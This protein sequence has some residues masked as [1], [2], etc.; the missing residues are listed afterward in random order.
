MKRV[1]GTCVLCGESFEHHAAWEQDT[2]KKCRRRISDKKSSPK[3][4]AKNRDAILRKARARTLDRENRKTYVKPHR[5]V[6][7]IQAGCACPDTYSKKEFYKW[8]DK[9]AFPIGTEY[10][11]DGVRHEILPLDIGNTI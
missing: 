11:L 1:T 8:L 9:D 2:C 7:V 5:G 6:Q 4:Y 3:Y 10:W